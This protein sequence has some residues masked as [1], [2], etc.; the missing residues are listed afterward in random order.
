MW[1]AEEAVGYP[2]DMSIEGLR[3]RRNVWFG[4]MDIKHVILAWRIP[5]TGE[6]GGLLSMG[7][8]WSWT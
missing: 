7:L 3:V 5:G 8:T 1:Q 6:P 2:R 4:K